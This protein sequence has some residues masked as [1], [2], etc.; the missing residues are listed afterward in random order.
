MDDSQQSTELSNILVTLDGSEFSEQILDMVVP[1]ARAIGARL[2][3]LHVVSPASRMITGLNDFQRPLP[4]RG[5]AMTYLEHVASRMPSTM[6]KP[7]LI[8]AEAGDAAAAIITELSRGTHDALAIATHGRSGL[9][10]LVL[11]SVAE[12]VLRAT[13]QPL[14]LYRPRLVPLATARIADAFRIHGE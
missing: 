1:F 6:P 4:H 2:S 8:A 14:M 9:S 3:L 12:E 10:R 11:G 5:E 7:E 13:D